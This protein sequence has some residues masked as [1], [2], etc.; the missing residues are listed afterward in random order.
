MEYSTSNFIWKTLNKS[1]DVEL[2]SRLRDELKRI[3]MLSNI[4]QEEKGL[5]K[6]LWLLCDDWLTE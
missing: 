5:Y 6:E 2:I 3:S 4:T 1:C